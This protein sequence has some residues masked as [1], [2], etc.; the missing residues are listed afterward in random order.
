MGILMSQHA[1]VT[2]GGSGMGRAIAVRLARAGWT[3]AVLG[4]RME[5]LQ[6]TAALAP[7]GAIRPEP[8]DVR[9]PDS[10]AVV[11]DRLLADWASIDLVVNVAGTNVKRRLLEQLSV[12]DFT[13]LIAVNLLGPFHVVHAF[14]PSMRAQGHGTIVNIGSDA[15]LLASAKAGAGYV[16]SKFGLTGLT[17]SINAELRGQ[18][19][20]ATAIFPGDTDTD[21]LEKRANPPRPED[22]AAMLQPDDIAE[23]V[24]L[25]V[26]LPQRVVVEKLLV[27]P[28]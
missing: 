28:R 5:R 23:C 26:T 22:R 16:S 4:R 1:V 12:E 9:D 14:L 19:I 11:R 10:V 24:M 25:V 18:G 15:G 21:L 2:G 7:D 6:E 13:E 3:V 17:E 20:R 8:V 27:R